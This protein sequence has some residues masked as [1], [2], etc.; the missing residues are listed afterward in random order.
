[1]IEFFR[2]YWFLVAVIGAIITISGRLYA[3]WNMPDKM[4]EYEESQQAYYEKQQE[5][6]TQQQAYQAGWEVWRK[7]Q[8]NKNAAYFAW[9]RELERK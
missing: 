5:Y 3:V 4:S 6:V 1:M 8:E 9:L 7:E 2:K